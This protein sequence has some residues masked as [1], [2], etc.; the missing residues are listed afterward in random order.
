VVIVLLVLA[1]VAGLAAPLLRGDDATRLRQAAR[2]LAADL[3][4]ARVQTITHA[5]APRV[6]VFDPASDAYHLA[7]ADAPAVPITDPV[8]KGPHRVRFGHGR[9]ESLAGVTLAALDV[10]EGNRLTF[11]IYGQLQRDQPAVITLASGGRRL[12][13]TLDP[14]S[15]EPT[16]GAIH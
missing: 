1:V 13:L 16:I 8:T 14:T 7:H 4:S 5:D 10:G 9:A 6:V 15:G 3:A 12:T 2:L 11:G